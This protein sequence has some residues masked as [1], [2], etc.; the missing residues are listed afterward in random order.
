MKSLL[1]ALITIAL[2]S[3]GESKEDKQLEKAKQL[4]EET[5]RKRRSDSIDVDN[6]MKLESAKHRL[7][8]NDTLTDAQRLKKAEEAFK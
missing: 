6:K 8:K 2:L 4:I 5:N 1:F 7:G 3:C